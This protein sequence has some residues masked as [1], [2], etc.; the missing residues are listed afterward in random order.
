LIETDEA[1]PFWTELSKIPYNQM[2]QDD[3][4]WLP[5]VVDGTKFRGFFVFEV[6]QLLNYKVCLL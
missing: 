3:P 4:H 5:L 6:E 2:W 1:K